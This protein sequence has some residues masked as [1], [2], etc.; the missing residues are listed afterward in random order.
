MRNLLTLPWQ[1]KLEP[2]RLTER[3]HL[4]CK[5]SLQQIFTSYVRDSAPLQILKILD[6]SKN[7]I[8]NYLYT[9]HKL[10]VKEITQ[11]FTEAIV[12]LI[13]TIKI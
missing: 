7:D 6:I 4:Q 13:P 1:A 11:K 9:L 3:T 10:I 12:K 5:K 2:S 8:C